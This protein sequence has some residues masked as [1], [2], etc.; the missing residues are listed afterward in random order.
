MWTGSVEFKNTILL[1]FCDY[2]N[3]YA[4]SINTTLP[5]ISYRKRGQLSLMNHK[6]GEI[7]EKEG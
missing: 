4:D 7:K 1:C 3:N 2:G 5:H 6:Q